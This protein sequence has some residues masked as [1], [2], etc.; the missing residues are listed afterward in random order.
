MNRLNYKEYFANV[1]PCLGY[2]ICCGSV[3]GVTIFLFKIAA[4]KLEELS[5]LTYSFADRSPLYIPLIF[6]L[7]ALIAAAMWMLHRK[8]PQ[9]KGGGIPRSE[10]ILRGL[11]SFRG[12]TTLIGTLIGSFMSFFAG[13]PLGSEGP[14]VLI[15]TSIGGIF[16]DFSRHKSAW[17]RYIMSGGAGAGFAIATGAPLSAMLF[18][19]EEIHKRF[20]PML[21]LIVSTSVVAASYV[22]GLL[23]AHFELDSALFIIEEI[24][25]F[26]LEHVGYLLLL[27]VIVSLA[28][29]GFD[30]SIG[31]IKKLTTRIGGKFHDITRLLIVFFLTGVLAIT[32]T[33]GVYSGHH[34]VVEVIENHFTLG[35]LFLLLG[36]R[37]LLML[38]VTDSGATGGI[39]IPTLAIGALLSALIAKLLFA[40]GM[41]QE[42]F[43]AVVLLGMCAFIGGTLRS[44]LTAS[45]LFLE[46][47]G[48]FTDL[49]YVLLVIF[50]V[51]FITEIFHQKPFYDRVLER[52]EEAQN[53]G[54]TVKIGFFE[55]KVSGGA[56][57]IG[58]AVRDIMWPSSSV[59]ISVTRAEGNF[60]DM[61]NDGEKNLYEGD[62]LV[63]RAKYF[64]EEE[65]KN[66]LFDLVGREHEIRTI[67]DL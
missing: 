53:H 27:G 12:P 10:G 63:L 23:C 58:K 60:Q 14:A 16:S 34:V 25:P 6:L 19:L 2:G 7:L 62:T 59:V 17:N 45:V 30:A 55:M 24:S 9:V 28:V 47:T 42:L 65:I 35:M 64:D 29:A 5:R 66:H 50:T 37:M 11:L 36:I 67:D 26:E 33:E 56:F 32:I 46:L 8:L 51:N 54:R 18:V 13:L 1:I 52:M 61:D 49:F 43:G 22:N 38:L 41:P 20:T 57:V 4:K 39:F 21:I 15:G 40:I 48:Q 44:P 31:W 3:T